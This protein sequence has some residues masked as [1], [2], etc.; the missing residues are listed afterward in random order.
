MSTL[1][2]KIKSNYLVKDGFGINTQ[3]FS[4]LYVP[5]VLPPE[6]EKTF[7]DNVIEVLYL[8]KISFGGSLNL[9]KW[10]YPRGL[11][12]FNFKTDNVQ[13]NFESN[14]KDRFFVMYHIGFNPEILLVKIKLRTDEQYKNDDKSYKFFRRYERNNDSKFDQ[15]KIA[16]SY[17]VKE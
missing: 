10:S 4:A 1:R 11:F 6:N 14:F 7:T 13:F 17:K 12:V 9:V 16:V 15:N 3:S 5:F 8:D 2:C